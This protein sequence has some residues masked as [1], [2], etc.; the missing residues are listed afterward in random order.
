MLADKTGYFLTLGKGYSDPGFCFMQQ[1]ETFEKLTFDETF[2]DRAV[3]PDKHQ[4]K[5][6]LTSGYDFVDVGTNTMLEIL[7]RFVTDET[8]YGYVHSDWQK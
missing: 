7:N 3:D 8:Y 5:V 6:T 1:P 4:I 2:G